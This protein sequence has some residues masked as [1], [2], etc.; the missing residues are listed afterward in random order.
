MLSVACMQLKL[1]VHRSGSSAL[2]QA[3]AF[4]RSWSVMDTISVETG[5]MNRTAI[6]RLLV[7]VSSK[8]TSAHPVTRLNCHQATY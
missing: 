5:P 1:R 4:H 7:N 3:A 6:T 8:Q 2:S